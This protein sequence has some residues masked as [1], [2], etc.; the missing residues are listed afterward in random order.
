MLVYT[1]L[2]VINTATACLEEEEEGGCVC[3]FL[4]S[5]GKAWEDVA[6]VIHSAA[7]LQG[8][9]GTHGQSSIM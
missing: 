7:R 8:E 4:S 3:V 2:P 5:S 9:G 6:Y 1:F